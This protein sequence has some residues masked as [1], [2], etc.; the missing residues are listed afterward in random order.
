MTTTMTQTL[1]QPVPPFTA[2]AISVSLPTWRDNVGYEEGEK[3]VVNVMVTGYPRFFIHKSI[4]KLASI[5]EKKFGSHEERCMIFPSKKTAE[6][7]R[8]FMAKHSP[9]T[10]SPVPVRLVEFVVC[11]DEITAPSDSRCID[12]HIVL[13]P[14]NAFPIAKKFWQHTGMGISS[15]TAVRCLT[16]MSESPTSPTTRDHFPALNRLPS[17]PQNRHYIVKSPPPPPH[18]EEVEDVNSYLEERYGRNL[19]LGYAVA[20]KRALRRRIAGVLVH[21]QCYNTQDTQCLPEA[22][23]A[24]TMLGPSS[25]GVEN[26]TEDDVFLYPTGMSAIWWAHHLALLTRPQQK[27]VCFGFPYTDTLK[28]LEKW[29]PGCYH[30]GHGLDSDIDALEKLLEELSPNYSLS[31]DP[32]ILTLFTEFPSNPLLRSANLPRLRALADK[33]DFLIVV[34]E[35]IG[36]FVNVSV[37]PYADIVVSSLTKVFSGDSN[38]MGG[39]L[40][41]NPNGKHYATLKSILQK[42]FDDIYFDEDAIFMERNSRN[43]RRRV[44]TINENAEAVC[45]FLKSFCSSAAGGPPLVKEVYY[46]KFVTRENYDACRAVDLPPD[47]SAFGGLFS[48]TFTQLTAS[49]AFF[50]ALECMK[51]P[52][53][54]TSFTLA[55]P[56][57]IIAHYEELDW[58]EKWGVEKGLVRVSIGTEEK[59]EL[60]SVFRKALEAAEAAVRTLN[61]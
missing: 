44:Q 6:F 3:R 52:S 47:A 57:T 38:V 40:V 32:P 42:E 39:S 33:Y 34:D 9:N 13:F 7:C 10:Q 58:A 30:F 29:G 5:C 11:P 28:I 31:S 16:R 14:A 53:L 49:H 4:Q 12:L 60:L 59:E 43:F 35:T 26:V 45:D 37:L 15:R 20:A 21:D 48:V 19:P 25:R 27:S 18:E 46:P 23:A 22:G 2:H 41:L 61:A 1:G 17:K 55:C 51:G 56:Y 24:E 8:E 54:G 36:N 50:D